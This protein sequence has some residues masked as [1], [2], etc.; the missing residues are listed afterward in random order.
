MSE[1]DFVIPPKA[2]R[3]MGETE[4]SFLPIA[5]HLATKVL[6]VM[7]GQSRFDLLDMG[8]GYG[9][10][11]YGLRRAGFQGRY[12]GFDILGEHIDWLNRHFAA[13]D[14]AARYDFDF[15]NVHNA[16]Y[17]PHGQPFDALA[18][19]YV[20]DSVDCIVAYS[21]FT[22][23][24]E[25]DIRQYLRRVGRL[26]RAGGAWLATFFSVPDD[27]TLEAQDPQM[28]YRLTRQIS[29]VAWIHNE[30]EPLHVIAYQDT[31]LRRLFAEEGFSVLTHQ[32]GSWLGDPNA[33]EFQDCFILRKQGVAA[34]APAGSATPACNICGG[35]T[36]GPGPSGRMASTG[37]APCCRQCG[38][39]ERQRV[40]RQI[41]QALPIGFLDWRRS[42]QFSPD[43]AADPAWFR[44]HE[45]SIYGGSSSLDIQAID[46]PD[47]SYD[48]VTLSHVLECIPRDLDSFAELHRIL[49]PH[50][51]LHIGFAAPQ[52]RPQTRE[53]A[54]AVD[55]HGNRRLYGRDIFQHFGCA[56]KQMGMLVVEATDPVTGATDVAYLF[57]RHAPDIARMGEWLGGWPDRL[58][59]IEAVMP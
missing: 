29:P 54:D 12:R 40:V 58:T 47:G 9:R 50:G 25:S 4:E 2:L 36:F 5:D 31:F 33:G 35:R 46:R 18:L 8:C 30:A 27:F 56:A 43:Q 48:F 15:L 55:P 26:L 28:R 11:A 44:S 34:A 51:M 10:L 37:K 13:P 14:D 59:I 52:S 57:A 23:M 21:V 41:F 38:A 19:P 16:R 49:S 22:H 3:F 17:N 45:V 53:F 32:P 7:H 42:L 24:Y 20:A 39:L 1:T 6:N